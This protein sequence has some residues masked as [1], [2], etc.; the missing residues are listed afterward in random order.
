[1]SKY[2]TFIKS[3]CSLYQYTIH[4]GIDTFICTTSSAGWNMSDLEVTT[5]TINEEKG[6]INTFCHHED[7][8]GESRVSP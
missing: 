3:P 8:D 5:F 7:M 1:M 2:Q 4:I 6:H